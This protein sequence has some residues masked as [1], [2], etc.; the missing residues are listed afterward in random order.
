MPV[1]G[2]RMVCK[3]AS[4]KYIKE[5][6]QKNLERETKLGRWVKEKTERK[7]AL[8]DLKERVRQASIIPDSLPNSSP[9]YNN[10]E[11]DMTG[12]E[13]ENHN[14]MNNTDNTD[15][16][17]N[18]SIYSQNDKSRRTSQVND[19]DKQISEEEQ[20]GRRDTIVSTQDIKITSR[21]PSRWNPCSQCSIQ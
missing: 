9:S 3:T 4:Y 14:N 5:R 19:K 8:H 18:S 16:K 13:V 7:A 1:F 17:D 12:E 6:D 2:N 10:L 21:E 11:E 20:T 15:V